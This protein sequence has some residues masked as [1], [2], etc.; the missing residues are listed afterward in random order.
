MQGRPVNPEVLSAGVIWM[1][2]DITERKQSEQALRASREQFRALAARVQTVREEERGRVAREIHDVLAQ[3]LTSLKIDV[4]LL[5]HLL[6]GP[7]GTP[8]NGLVREK[9]AS[10]TL[11]TDEAIQSV[12]KIATELRPMVLDSLGLCAAI[13]WQLQD[14]QGRTGIQCQS[15]LPAEDPPLDQNRSTALFRILQESLTNVARHA[16]ATRVDIRL[17]SEPEKITLVVSDNGRGIPESQANAPGAMGLLGMRERALLLGGRCEISGSP[18][19]GT[20]VEAQLPLA[21]NGLSGDMHT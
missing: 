3:E 19:Q 15:S 18:G 12:Q 9:L 5:S 14:F 7:S 20:R 11:A 4:T 13:E 17:Q 6:A 8:A 2:M 10:M 1:L 21:P 16:A